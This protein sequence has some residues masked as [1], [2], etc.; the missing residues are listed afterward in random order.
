MLCGGLRAPLSLLSACHNDRTVAVGQGFCVFLSPPPHHPSTFAKMRALAADDRVAAS[1]T[2]H[3]QIRYRLV[4]DPT[5]RRVTNVMAP[6]DKIL[7]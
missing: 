6:L 2:S 1:W 7:G 4:D 3:G 5:I